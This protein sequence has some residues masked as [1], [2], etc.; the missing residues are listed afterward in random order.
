MNIVN[1]DEAQAAEAMLVLNMI[2]LVK[3]GP[4]Y[5]EKVP[6]TSHCLAMLYFLRED[7]VKVTSTLLN[8]IPF[9][10]ISPVMTILVLSGDWSMPT[11]A[12]DFLYSFRNNY[13]SVLLGYWFAYIVYC[14]YIHLYV[15]S[16]PCTSTICML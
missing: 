10:C 6:K 2:Y 9:T 11:T 12:N 4:Q 8:Y 14:T 15:K 13:C 7:G 5:P 16:I 3:N 1:T